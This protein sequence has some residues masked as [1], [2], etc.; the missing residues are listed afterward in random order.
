MVYTIVT[1]IRIRLHRKENERIQ[2]SKSSTMAMAW[3]IAGPGPDNPKYRFE[4]Y[5]LLFLS[6]ISVYVAAFALQIANQEFRRR[7]LGK[8]TGFVQFY[9]RPILLLSSIIL[10]ISHIDMFG[11]FGILTEPAVMFLEFHFLL[12]IFG[13][14]GIYIFVMTKTLESVI[15]TPSKTTFRLNLLF[16]CVLALNGYA[17]TTL[18]IVVNQSW[19]IVY[20]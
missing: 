2:P 19:T 20:Q 9:G 17:S 12:G 6:A 13:F 1:H 7:I 14:L 3:L 8:T 15:T 18:R 4:L 5:R 11:Q 10:L 16:Y